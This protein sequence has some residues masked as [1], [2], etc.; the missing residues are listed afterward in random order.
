MKRK[1]FRK[2]VAAI[3]LA[4]MMAFAT[5]CGG[6]GDNSDGTSASA[7][8]Q[9][10]EAAISGKGMKTAFL[11]ENITDQIVKSDDEALKVIRSVMD[12]LGGD[13]TTALTIDSVRP[14]ET[15]LTYYVFSQISGDIRIKGAE[16]KLITDK[17]G[18]VVGISSAI[19][20]GVEKKDYSSW[21]VSEKDAEGVV[22]KKYPG[23]KVIP[24]TTEAT[25]LPMFGVADVMYYA[26]VVYT[27]AVDDNAEAL[28]T[29]HYVSMAGSYLYSIPVSEPGSREAAV[30]A[31]LNFSFDKGKKEMWKGSVKHT[32]GT[33]EDIEVPVIRT[34]DGKIVL[35]D[36]ER[37]ILCAD[38]VDY[39]SN[40]KMTPIAEENGTFDNNILLSYYNMERIYDFFNDE[41]GWEGADGEGTPILLLQNAVNAEG[42]PMDNAVYVGDNAGFQ[43]FAI[44]NTK[45]FADCMDIMAHEFTHCITHTFLTATLY[46]ND[47]GAINEALSDIIGNIVEVELGGP[48]AGQWIIGENL[49]TPLRYMADPHKGKQPAY[50][51]D[52][53]Y[54]PEAKPVA[55]ANDY[56]GVHTNSSFLNL[57]SYRLKEVGMSPADQCYFWMN[58]D[59][60]ITPRT[61][62]TQ[63]AQIL[64]WSLKQ[65]GFE[66]YMDALNKAIE[67][68]GIAG[69]KV[70]E[71]VPEGCARVMIDYDMSS[72]MN[73]YTV[74]LFLA[75]MDAVAKASSPEQMEGSVLWPV[76][77]TG[78][79]MKNVPA[80]TYM[81]T[82]DLE[83]VQMLSTK[84]KISLFYVDGK[85]RNTNEV[86]ESWAQ[87]P[88]TLKNSL[89]TVENG[90]EIKIPTEGLAELL[91]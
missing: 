71:K 3:F 46:E 6:S 57:I 24:E 21:A 19:L 40:N 52:M 22:E 79:I 7:G 37:K 49:G 1:A 27:K 4:G 56:G 81:M 29:A 26:W 13:S 54:C 45:P 63:I 39:N 75:E 83:P 70:P 76:A 87:D 72:Y 53:Y 62:F 91:K 8:H 23:F 33:K 60:S 61:D 41:I 86:S 89:I 16:V 51:W 74:Q 15:G 43:V 82:M 36:P 50:V 14:T 30:G 84:E 47:F 2:S 12:K 59:L 88:E 25:I 20:P 65:T 34:D 32:D 9:Y 66:Q 58:V 73:D 17:D 35:A 38:Y 85:W 78:K 64:P 48:E 90:K 44:D 31:E 69:E 10:D 5:A 28:Y 55:E 11:S 77:S 80:G 18:K 67:E 42:K 68:T